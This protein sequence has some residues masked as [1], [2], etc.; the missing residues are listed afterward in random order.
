MIMRGASTLGYGQTT[1]RMRLQIQLEPPRI[2]PRTSALDLPCHAFAT[3]R[4]YGGCVGPNGPFGGSQR[5]GVKTG[6]GR[7]RMA[8]CGTGDGG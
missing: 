8:V 5:E 7:L 6:Q 4:C 2:Y 3:P 1:S